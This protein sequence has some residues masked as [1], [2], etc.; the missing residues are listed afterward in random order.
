MDLQP[1][2]QDSSAGL[3]VTDADFRIIWAN[4]FEEDYY[5]KSLAE[6]QGLWVVNCHQ[7]AN[8][9]KINNFLQEFKRGQL[10]EYTKI[11]NG[12]VITYSSYKKNGEFAGLVR[13]R[14]RIPA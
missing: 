2:L 5:G 4:K 14:I 6:L 3:L 8:R 12:M 1:I 13:T 7:E 10:K 11:A 9:E